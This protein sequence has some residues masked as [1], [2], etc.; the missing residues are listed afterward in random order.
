MYSEL[1]ISTYNNPR[2][3]DLC[4][5]SVAMQRTAPDGVC[6]ADDGSGPETRA[7]AERFA[8]RLPRL[9]HVWHE[10]RGFEKGE[11]L[12]K[13]IASS[14]A[15]V[16]V[17]IDGDVMIHPDFITRHLNLARPGRFATGS[18][19]RLDAAATASVTAAM[20]RSGQVFSRRW[21]RENRALGKL[22]TWLKTRPFPV[23]VMDV[24][25][26]MSPVRRSLCGANASVCRSDLLKI[27]GYDETLKYGGQDKHLGVRLKNAGVRG[28]HL[29]YSAPLVHLD[30]PRGYADPERKKRHKALIRAAR[31]SGESWTAHG[32]EKDPR[33]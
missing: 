1:V 12:N 6:I 25:E 17:F 22:S 3:L 5:E 10:D 29:R 31:R 16:L 15:E 32:I 23:P 27:N 13:A 18:L 2:A 30:H 28:R 33:T 9:R 11:I 26:R 21:L 20:V 4:L 14:Q 8:T 24:L 19:I 7:V